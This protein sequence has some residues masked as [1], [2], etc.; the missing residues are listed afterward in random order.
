MGCSLLI[1]IQMTVHGVASPSASQQGVCAWT[2]GVERT[3]SRERS[4]N[5][6]R[7][8]M[9]LP[10]SLGAFLL[11]PALVFWALVHSAV[12]QGA[13]LQEAGPSVG[14][15]LGSWTQQGGRLAVFSLREMS[16]DVAW[17]QWGGPPWSAQIRFPVAS[18]HCKH[19]GWTGHLS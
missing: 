8:R 19:S 18:E 15:W 16:V 1:L 10:F 5:L 7:R 9:S 4:M 2:E 17:A 14:G 11:G 3:C 12:I 13:C 6:T